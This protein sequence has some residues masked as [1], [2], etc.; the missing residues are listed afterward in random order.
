MVYTQHLWQNC[1]PNPAGC[2]PQNGTWTYPRSGWCPGSFGT[3]WNFNLD[4]YIANGSADLTY[5]FDPTYIDECHPNFPDCVTGQ[6]NCPNC[7]DSDNP[8]LRVSG[9]LVTYSHG[10]D[11]ILNTPEL[12]DV[13]KDPFQVS[14]TP[15][16]VKNNMTITTDYTKGR[17]SVHILN[18]QG[19]EVRGFSMNGSATIDVSD[20]P[21]GLYFVNIIGGK[22][23]TKK[24]MIE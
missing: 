14:I 13:D 12:P 5:E 15:N 11:M 19:T 7:Q 17:M 18:A 3:V 1:N 21:A 8:I 23:V 4:N 24:V 22:V 10:T 6:N 20:L 9:K 2:Q 16:P